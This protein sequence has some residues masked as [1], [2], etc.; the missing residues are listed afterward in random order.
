M[1]LILTFILCV[2]TW[3]VFA[4]H[5]TISVEKEEDF[6]PR[7]TG[8]AGGEISRYY[9]CDS[10]GI[11]IGHDSKVVSFVL[12]FLDEKSQEVEIAIKGNKLTDDHCKLV[13]NA[14]VGTMV[15]FQDIMVESKG[16]KVKVTPMMFKIKD[17]D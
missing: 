16:V 5:G 2:L 3:G 6:L 17:E 4:Q 10:K 1:K 15:Y 13:M 12:Y 9:L 8:K 11:T 7:I 14:P